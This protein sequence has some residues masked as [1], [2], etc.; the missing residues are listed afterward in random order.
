MGKIFNVNAD[1]HP[2]LHYMVDLK[3]RLGKIKKMVDAGQYFTINRA[4]QY[5]KTTT[6]L[7]LAEYLQ[8]DYIVVSL[9][10]QLFSAGTF[11]TENTFS[12]SFAK[13]FAKAW[14]EYNTSCPDVISQKLELLNT[15]VFEKKEDFG[16]QELFEH[17]CGL[18]RDS[19]SPVVL[20]IDETDSAAD[21]PVFLDF[22]SQLR[23]YYI[24]RRRNPIFQSVILAG[25][26]DIKNLKHRFVKNSER[27]YNSPWNIAADFLID[28]NFSKEE[29]AGMLIQYEAD[30]HTGMD[31]ELIA[32]LLYDYTSGYPFL[33]SKICK[34]IDEHVAES[35]NAPDKSTAW[36]KTG[37]L[38]SVS[39]LLTEK[40]TLFE[41]LANKLTDY[42]ELRNM[43][44]SMLF[45]GKTIPYTPLNPAISIGEM[46]GFI[47]PQND[48]I[49]IANRIFETLLYNL[50][51]S[52]ELLDNKMYDAALN[53]KNQFIQN[54]HLNMRM[55]LEKFVEHFDDLYG[56]QDQTFYED[57]GRRYFLLYLRPIINGTGNYYIETQTRNKERTD[58]IVDYRGEQFVIELKLW[59][60]NSYHTR[61]ET[62][63]LDY[64]DY[65][66]LDKGYMLSFN[67]NK[68][69]QIGVQEIILDGKILVEAV[70]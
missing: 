58:I 47:K 23:G 6:L 59:R 29:I 7:A 66:H 55:V 43:L 50:F 34:L 60:G 15:A 3:D 26:Y 65:Y 48:M 21:S 57:D 67:F 4:R 5:G 2:D 22:L 45:T 14:K 41:S 51:L 54:G 24:Q 61:G 70:V 20:M 1:C 33:V 42:P 68:K 53:D 62:Q 17:L 69:K 8:K 38:E 49:V 10:F 13:A 44:Y 12:L 25:V 52:D 64:L 19:K 31:I 16:L 18:C 27:T 39:L 63:L 37:F 9:D 32:S 56:D 30:Y 46:F 35:E 11:K 40:N 36:T 28:M